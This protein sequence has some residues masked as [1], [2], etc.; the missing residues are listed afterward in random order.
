MVVKVP[1]NKDAALKEATFLTILKNLPYTAKLLDCYIN[2]EGNYSLVLKK[3][4]VEE[5]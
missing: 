4:P 1:S 5:G 2:K 3:V